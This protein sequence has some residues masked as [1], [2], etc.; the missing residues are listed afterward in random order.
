MRCDTWYV[1]VDVRSDAEEL[2]CAVIHAFLI[3]WC[4]LR[5]RLPIRHRMTQDVLWWWRCCSA[6]GEVLPPVIR[7]GR[8]TIECQLWYDTVEVD[9][10]NNILRWGMG[11]TWCDTRY[12]RA[13]S[14]GDDIC[15]DVYYF[16]PMMWYGT[17]CDEHKILYDDRGDTIRYQ[18]SYNVVTLV[19]MR[20][21]RWYDM[22]CVWCDVRYVTTVM[23][24][25]VMSTTYYY[26]VNR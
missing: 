20:D 22:V 7:C 14:I 4:E 3:L 17:W 8:G 13:D 10:L 2:K 1:W 25:S 18:M 21:L 6:R 16:V 23:R 19:G 5:H 15:C 12:D 11:Y 26:D 9:T 24:W